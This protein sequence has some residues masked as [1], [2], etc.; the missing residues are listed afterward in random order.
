[1][2]ADLYPYIAGGTGLD[3]TLPSWVFRD[4]IAKVGEKLQDPA[5]RERLKKEIA[6]G[7]QPGWANL[8]EA[9]GGW[10]GVILANAHNQEFD[11]FRF[12]S[13][14]D[15]A[16]EL[17][18]DPTEL[19]W[20][21][22]AKAA[23]NRAVAL[24]FLVD[25]GDVRTALLYPWTT[26]G[27]DAA[28]AVGDSK[29]DALGLPHPR[30]YGT[31]PRVIAEYVKRQKLLPLETAVHKMTG[32]AATRMK[33]K[34]RGFLRAGQWADITIFDLDRLDDRATFE[35]PSA[36]PEGIDYVLVNGTLVLE[37]G[38]YSGALPGKVV[39]GAGYRPVTGK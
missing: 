3:A 19:S 1:V 11:R 10:K 25:E 37:G 21:I 34:D 26:I 7:S 18:R 8:V 2:A 31:F 22:M 12:R 15:I 20:E 24:F 14:A 38:K 29:V 36:Q 28:A 33:L 35:D 39:R 32:L 27:S 30:S 23:P 13:I 16:A 4:G 9:S 17:G 5:I 6:A